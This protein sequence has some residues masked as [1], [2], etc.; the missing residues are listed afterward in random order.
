VKRG[1]DCW[2]KHLL[3]H[4]L[5]LIMSSDGTRNQIPRAVLAHR[6][7]PHSLHISE[8]V[9]RFFIFLSTQLTPST[10]FGV[11][12][13]VSEETPLVLLNSTR[14]LVRLLS[15]HYISLPQFIDPS[16]VSSSKTQVLP[17]L[18]APLCCQELTSPF[19]CVSSID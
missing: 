18:S 3:L 12:N 16:Q 10:C 1:A 8:P 11:D 4:L 13:L 5:L 6:G 17:S 7:P 14:T 15:R 2:G 9:L 19:W